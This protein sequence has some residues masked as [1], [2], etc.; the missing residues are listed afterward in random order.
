MGVRCCRSTDGSWSSDVVGRAAGLVLEADGCS[1]VARWVSTHLDLGVAAGRI[2]WIL[3]IDVGFAGS[4]VDLLLL[5]WDLLMD[6]EDEVAY[7]KEMQMGVGRCCCRWRK[8]RM[9]ADDGAWPLLARAEGRPNAAGSGEEMQMGWIGEDDGAPYWC[10][11]LWRITI[12]CVP[13]M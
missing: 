10:S 1:W 11:V 7:S 9:G 4:S 5:A 13:A 8:W 2:A 3:A 12:N 6:G